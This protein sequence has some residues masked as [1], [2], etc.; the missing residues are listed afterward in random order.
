[1]ESRDIRFVQD[2]IV[3]AIPAE[4]DLFLLIEFDRKGDLRRGLQRR[5]VRQAHHHAW[6]LAVDAQHIPM[7]E[8]LSSHDRAALA[9]ERV[10]RAGN[11]HDLITA[12]GQ[13]QRSMV[14]RDNHGLYNDV[15]FIGAAERDTVAIQEMGDRLVA[16]HRDQQLGRG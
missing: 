2:D 6:Q 16:C 13:L 4:G 10:R 14:A 15:I 5:L 12:G 7:G 8:K 11:D 1:M 9:S 3:P